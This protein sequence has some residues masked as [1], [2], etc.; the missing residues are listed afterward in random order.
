MLFKRKKGTM[1]KPQEQLFIYI[2]VA[3]KK[4]IIR[5]RIVIKQSGSKGMS[6]NWSRVA[7]S[8][9]SWQKLTLVLSGGEQVSKH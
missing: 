5:R 8:P 3:V 1:I 2:L 7:T 4:I 9:S 6:P